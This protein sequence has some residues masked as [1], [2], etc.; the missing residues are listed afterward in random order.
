LKLCQEWGEGRIK[1]KDGGG[2]FSS[3]I[4]TFVNVMTYP[5]Y[6]NMIIKKYALQTQ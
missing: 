1:E 4:R 2:E 3:D 6:Y 5:Q